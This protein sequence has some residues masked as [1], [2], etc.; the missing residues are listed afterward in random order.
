VLLEEEAAAALSDPASAAASPTVPFYSLLVCSKLRMFCGCI[1]G[2]V[3]LRAW[4]GQARQQV[5]FSSAIRRIPVRW[6]RRS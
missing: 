2:G 1:S 5:L 6:G 4:S 3:W